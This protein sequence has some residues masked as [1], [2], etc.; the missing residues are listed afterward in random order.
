MGEFRPETN[1]GRA[2]RLLAAL[3]EAIERRG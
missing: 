2:R 1:D 3:Y